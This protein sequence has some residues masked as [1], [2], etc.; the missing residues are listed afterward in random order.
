MT[1][2]YKVIE[3]DTTSQWAMAVIRWN[4]GVTYPEVH[5][6]FWVG[7]VSETVQQF[8][9]EYQI[10]GESDEW[11]FCV[12]NWGSDVHATILLDNLKIEKVA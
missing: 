12:S 8:S 6:A 1:F 7:S 5:Q 2:D 9:F 11:K 4:D 10:T 3:A